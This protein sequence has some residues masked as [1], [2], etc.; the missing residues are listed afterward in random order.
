MVGNRVVRSVAAA[1][2]LLLG[3]VACGDDDDASVDDTSSTAEGTPTSL[4][5]PDG[6]EIGAGVN[7]PEDPTIVVTEF[8][9]EKVTVAVGTPVTW[10][11]N[12][13]EPH[14]VTFTAP[15]QTLPPPGDPSVFEPTPPT[16]PVDGSAL[17][18]S[19]LVPL[20][21]GAPPPFELTFAKAGA[22]EY[23]C[24]I[25][26]AMV[27]TITVVDE[28]GAEDTPEDVAQARADEQATYLEEGRAV[29][30]GLADAEP[31]KTEGADGSTTW[32]VKMGATTEHV[33]VLAFAPVPTEAQAG[34]KITFLNDSGAPHTATFFGTDAEPI[35]SPLDPKVEAPAPGPSP[36]A[37]DAKGFFNTGLLP[38]NAPPGSGPPQAVRSFTFEL[39]EAGDFG[40]VCMLHAP[41]QMV[42]T[43]KVT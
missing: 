31:E 1:A 13:A 9:P 37:L 22:Y 6:I 10:T 39:P 41:S 27:G 4:D 42:G 20:G 43:I 16:G 3:V 11:W 40:Y 32:T 38:P 34:D 33:D 15:G 21:P 28:G 7:D 19:G 29:K 8:L 25:H 2:V 26:P 24:V 23:Y 14:S 30:A 5:V 35:S 18:N 12:G 17:V 36:Q